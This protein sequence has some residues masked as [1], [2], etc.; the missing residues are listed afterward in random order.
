MVTFIVLGRFALK[1]DQDDEQISCKPRPEAASDRIDF[2]RKTCKLKRIVHVLLFN[3]FVSNDRM[4]T[5]PT[6]TSS[7]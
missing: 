2:G 1:H 6:I 4:A 7:I 5:K 3:P